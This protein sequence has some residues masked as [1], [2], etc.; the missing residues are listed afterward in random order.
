MMK[1][2]DIVCDCYQVTVKEVKDYIEIPENK[3]KSLDVKLRELKISQ[4]CRFCWYKDEAENGKIDVH[5]SELIDV[6][7]EYV[8]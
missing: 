8:E 2:T 3:N 7:D 1:D 4:G 6:G 5:F